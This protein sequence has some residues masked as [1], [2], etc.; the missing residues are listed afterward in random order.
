MAKE[1]GFLTLGGF[2][3][4]NNSNSVQVIN[5]KKLDWSRSYQVNVTTIRVNNT[6]IDFPFSKVTSK[7]N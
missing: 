1:G 5:S 3:D 4:K 2:S 7:G 6:N